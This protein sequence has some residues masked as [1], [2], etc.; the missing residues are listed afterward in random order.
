MNLKSKSQVGIEYLVII[1]FV[2]F[3]I[4]STVILG[5]FYSNL[6]QDQIVMN[7]IESFAGKVISTSETVFYSGSPSRATINVYLPKK[8]D[9]IEIIGKELVIRSHIFSGQT[10]TSY[11]SNVPLSGSINPN[12]GIK[13]LRISAQDNNVTIS[14]A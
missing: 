1:G 7:Q 10:V 6:V 14:Q 5:Y 3:V 8:V 9:Q 11:F 12:A 2:T 4:I 13:K